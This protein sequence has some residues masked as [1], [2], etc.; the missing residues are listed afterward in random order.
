MKI[1][2]VELDAIERGEDRRAFKETMER[3]GIET[4]RSE[5]VYSVEEA[6]AIAVQLALGKKL[7]EMNLERRHVPHYGVKEAVFPFNMF[8]EVDPLLGPEM[9]STGEVLGMSDSFGMAYYKAQEATQMPLPISGTVLITVADADKPAVLEAARLLAD[10]GFRI[11]ATGGTHAFLVQHGIP[12]EP[13]L[14]LQEGRPHLV[15]IIKNRD[16]HL[17]INTPSGQGGQMDDS[18]IRKAAIRFKVPYITTTAAAIAAAWGIEAR[19][20]GI[21]QVKALQDYHLNIH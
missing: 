12:C 11:L 20:L 7:S 13:V 9:R 4:P 17:V 14:K 5:M 3:L 10:L 15:D 21:Q 18:Y 8:P 2:G 19:I 16:I 6:E 1:I